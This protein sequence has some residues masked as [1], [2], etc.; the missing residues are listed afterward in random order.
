MSNEHVIGVGLAGL[1]LGASLTVPYIAVD[2]RFRLVAAAD[3]RPEARD[4]FVA[5]TGGRPYPDIAAMARDPGVELVYVST[6]HYMH[7]DHAL[8]AIE[9]G[10][11][12]LVEKPLTRTAAEAV[13][14]VE[15]AG[16][17]GVRALY[18]HTHAFDPVI[19]EM[20]R[21]VEAGE[22]GRLGAIVNLNFNDIVYR[23]RA[24]WE[25]DGATSGGSPF[26][27]GAHQI[28][29]AR[30]IAGAPVTRVMGWS[31]ILDARRPMPGTHAAMLQFEN[32]AA[33]TL[34]LSGYAHFDTARWMDWRA[35]SGDP[36]PRT[37]HR[38]TAT[39]FERR[40][41][42]EVDEAAA[43]N[44]R[45]IG[46]Q[47]LATHPGSPR[48]E[49]FGVTIVSA[50]RGDLRQSPSG[51]ILEAGA[52]SRRIRI[53]PRSGRSI[54]LDEAHR[55]IRGGE[56][57]AIDAAWSVETVRIAGLIERG[58]IAARATPDGELRE[59]PG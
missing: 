37:A 57:V 23:P 22:V 6:P 13:E 59:L 24:D 11:H 29:I 53:A 50:E 31:A 33:A 56:A 27:Q 21:L 14:L 7:R 4:A 25:L 28:D 45:R 1:G 49:V 40:A 39:A 16:R 3:P 58:A 38:D 54:M 43:R 51:V 20:A 10:R 34:V 47:P 15:A 52:T 26:I 19:Q 9:A 12:V 46:L 55:A 48:H 17:R 30:W 41:R 2:S 44:S 8:T 18:G 35:E 36:R 42:G 32:G 5:A